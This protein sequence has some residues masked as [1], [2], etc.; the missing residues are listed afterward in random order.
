MIYRDILVL[1][2]IGKNICKLFENYLK[3]MGS[4]CCKSERNVGGAAD[5]SVRQGVIRRRRGG[6]SPYQVN[7]EKDLLEA[8]KDIPL[9]SLEGMVKMCKVV[10]VY[11]GDSCKIVLRLDGI[12]LVKF[13][14]RMNGYDTPEMRPPRDQEGREAEILAAKAAKKRL[15]DLIMGDKLVCVKCGKF[16]K[17]GRLLVDAYFNEEEC[18]MDRISVNQMMINEGF[19]YAYDGGTKKKFGN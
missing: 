7:F 16:D 5:V 9:F 19:G 10:E 6:K 18:L 11:D 4:I 14:C 15:I 2:N 12:G 17:Y 3:I 13:N 1:D 8:T